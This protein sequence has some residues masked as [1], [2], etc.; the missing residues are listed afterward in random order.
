MR[1]F[2]AIVVG[3][4][5]S[6]LSASSAMAQAPPPQVPTTVQLPT[7]NFFT[8]STTVSVPDRGGAYLG[9]ISRAADGSSTRGVGPLRNR[10]LSSTRSASSVSVHATIID[11]AEIDRAV[12]AEAAGRR[13][14]TASDAYSA[15]ADFISRHVGRDEAA[16][17][18]E[19]PAAARAG[20]ESIRREAQAAAEARAAEAAELFAKAEALETQG[21]PSI[22][23]IYYQMCAR[24]AADELKASAVARIA[25]IDAAGVASASA[26]GR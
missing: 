4:A 12:L 3:L 1:W 25:R 17:S 22:A 6:G 7:F 5:C 8:V 21:K 13:R 18:I 10:A 15:R 20:L 11:H 14:A 26:T 23:K 2:A 24:R 16:T 19:A 9:G